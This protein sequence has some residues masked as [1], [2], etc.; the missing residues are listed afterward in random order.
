M[1]EDQYREP[2]P[3]D[4]GEVLPGYEQPSDATMDEATRKR[5]APPAED[6]PPAED[7]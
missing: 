3:D 4:P 1:P 5:L 7:D 6:V 2:D